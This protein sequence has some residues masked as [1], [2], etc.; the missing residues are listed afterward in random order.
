MTE[1]KISRR[2][3]LKLAGA[4][5]ALTAVLTG[6]GPTSR[7]VTREPYTSMPEYNYNGKSTYYATACR[8]CPAGCGL[9]IRTVQGRAIKVEGNK[10]HPVNLGKTCS[11]AQTAVQGL[12]NPDRFHNPVRHTRGEST[13]V[14][15][16][17]DEAIAIV[18]TA[19]KNTP[20]SQ[21]A[22]VL[23][24]TSDH[25]YDLFSQLAQAVGA[26]KP[27]RF[28]PY[29][30]FEARATLAKAAQQAFGKADTLFF[31][32]ANADVT[33]SF[34]ANFLETW[35]SPVAYTRG[36]SKMRRGKN[37]RRGYFIQFESR[38][39]QT[40]ATADEWI[41]VV[42]GTEGM[43]ALAIGRVA[44]QLRAGALPAA[45]TNVNLEE[46]AQASGVDVETL[47]RLGRI[48]ANAESP[49][50]LPGGA[51]L[52]L[53]N[54][55]DTALAVL[56]LN[57]LA[58]NSGKQSNVFLTAASGIN[59][60]A[61]LATPKEM[62]D[63]I[64]KMNAGEIKTMFVHGANPLFD[65]PAQFGFGVALNNVEQVIS[66][67]SY[68]DE[69]A[70]QADY[71]FPD[72]TALESWGYQRV[73]AADRPALS[74]A[75]PVVVP[76]YNTRSTVDV[77]LAAAQQ[78]GGK[79]A[80]ALPFAD[81]VAF[82]ENAA[83][84]LIT[85]EGG[86]YSAP[87]IRTFMARFQQFGGWWT[88][89]AAPDAPASNRA[90]SLALKPVAAA[91]E[92]AGEYYLL[93]FVSPILG[94]GSLANRPWLQETPDPT[95]TVMWNTWVE[96]NP[97]TA[98]KLGLHD[99]D[100]VRLVT[101]FGAVEVAVYRYPA[102][103]PDVIAVPFGQGHTALGRYAEGRGINPLNLIAAKFNEAGDVN[104]AGMRVKIEKTGRQRQ[105]ARLESRLGVYG[106]GLH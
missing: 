31:D 104:F 103:R 39:S 12:Y 11:R 81:E 45:F 57:G 79:A 55:L 43:V 36:F 2:D 71:I 19:L 88:A 23:G 73:V 91:F 82:I 41:P 21:M 9:V 80:Q 3:F 18:T 98:D 50:A 34:G 16:D 53:N 29:A 64:K 68:P 102:I 99:D 27:H 33:F 65:L 63:L 97:K 10:N 13:F 48:Y 44:A 96:I 69:T 62:H 61:H 85:Q 67:A 24:M 46:V 56:A 101:D 40:G 94:D 106:D 74:G 76:F 93:P 42:P 32:V 28:S 1:E 89:D 77:M 49:I 26:P 20:A 72:H 52:S 51:P 4:G 35:I 70:M 6:C 84:A 87:E 105:L 17:W 92:G 7:Y 30:L 47:E 5:A 95:T 59:D 75:Q 83:L 90:T 54:G 22:F 15:M 14:D 8:E 66:F 78:A 86:F 100:I 37:G 60:E 25:V 58:E 38:M